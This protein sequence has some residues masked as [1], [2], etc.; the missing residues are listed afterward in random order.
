VSRHVAADAVVL[1]GGTSGVNAALQLARIGL[2]VA[3]LEQRRM[4]A[5]GARW[6]NGVLAWQFER[7]GLAVPER[8]EVHSCGG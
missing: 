7:A 5:G 4:G 1:G 3:L 6:L 2:D 8:P